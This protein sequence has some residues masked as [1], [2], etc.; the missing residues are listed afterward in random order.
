M[1]NQQD[2]EK[3]TELS[4]WFDTCNQLNTFPRVGDL[5]SFIDSDGYFYIG[6]IE[7]LSLWDNT[8]FL[9]V[10]MG[11]KHHSKVCPAIGSA[12]RTWKT[13]RNKQ[14][15]IQFVAYASSSDEVDNWLDD[16]YQAWCIANNK[17]LE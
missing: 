17:D 16:L 3:F 9:L 2:V 12:L 5:V 15:I 11:N 14:E 4:K 10:P 1:L 6:V 8:A 7:R 13:V